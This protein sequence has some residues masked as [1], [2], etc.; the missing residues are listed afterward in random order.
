M[1]VTKLYND[2]VEWWSPWPRGRAVNGCV[3]PGLAPGT[4]QEQ[5][6]PAMHCR[7][8][9]LSRELDLQA[10]IRVREKGLD[11]K[12]DVPARTLYMNPRPAVAVM[13]ER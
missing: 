6:A 8:I 3:L 2:C 1:I 7:D 11:A 12:R 5:S 10:E 9:N 4:P 13:V